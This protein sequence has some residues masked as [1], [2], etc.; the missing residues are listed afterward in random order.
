MLDK[1]SY[2]LLKS[3]Y[4]HDYLT[5][6]EIDDV[7]KITTPESSLNEYSQN[8][9]RKNLID[10]HYFRTTETG[11][12]EYDGYEI[13]LEGR[14]FVE[15]KRRQFWSFFFPYV[16]TTFIAFLSLITTIM[17]NYDSFLF[18][19]SKIVQIVHPS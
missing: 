3:M 17:T 19:F 5:Y 1:K 16:I 12:L 4:K 10:P 14:A 11:D 18:A 13:N 9:S 7:T 8:L 6:K 15:D 2:K